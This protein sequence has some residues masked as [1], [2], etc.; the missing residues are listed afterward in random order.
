MGGV[1]GE[2]AAGGQ[3]GAEGGGPPEE[4][5]R[6]WGRVGSTEY[7]LRLLLTWFLKKIPVIIPPL[8]LAQPD[9]H[10]SQSYLQ[11]GGGGS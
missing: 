7:L 3:A 6:T 1:P 5:V 4:G 8:F 2:A 10:L 11:E 9:A